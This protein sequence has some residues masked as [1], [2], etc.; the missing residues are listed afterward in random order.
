[1]IG[2]VRVAVIKFINR[3]NKTLVGLKRNLDY[4]LDPKKT[5]ENLIYGKD[6]DYKNAYQDMC[7][8]KY[9]YGK[10]EGRQHIHF[11]QSFSGDELSY[12]LAKKIGQKILEMDIFSGYQ[13]VMATHTDTK[14]TH[15]H[16]VINTVNVDTGEKWKLSKEELQEI[17]DY[18]DELCEENGLQV[19]D[20][21]YKTTREY[22]SL[23]RE[24]T[25]QKEMYEL[26]LNASHESKT[27]ESFFEIIKKNGK[28]LHWDVK[29][30]YSKSKELE[31]ILNACKYHAQ[32]TT[33]FKED[34]AYYGA[35]CTWKVRAMIENK[36]T[37]EKEEKVFN[38]F[39]E[40]EEYKE[41][42]QETIE[43]KS[44]GDEIKFLYEGREYTPAHFIKNL[45]YEGSTLREQFEVNLVRN[46]DK[47][48]PKKLKEVGSSDDYKL[49]YRT[50][51]VARQ[52][53]LNQSEFEEN[54][55]RLGY[56]VTWK[57]SRKY[58]TFLVPKANGGIQKIRNNRFYPK[59]SFT[60]EAFYEVFAFNQKMLEIIREEG[61]SSVDELQE[62]V[63]LG[64][65]KD[66]RI[67]DKNGRIYLKHFFANTPK[68]KGEEQN[69]EENSMEE[70]E[71][72]FDRISLERFFT[73]PE[74][75]KI[76]M[77]DEIVE[78]KEI[79]ENKNIAVIED[80]KGYLFSLTSLSKRFTMDNL[81][82]RFCNNR[83]KEKRKQVV[84][85][86]R[87]IIYCS[88]SMSEFKEKLEIAGYRMEKRKLTKEDRGMI[89][90][91]EQYDHIG[92]EECL[93]FYD[94]E[95]DGFL[96]TFGS[97]GLSEENILRILQKNEE[98]IMAWKR[99]RNFQDFLRG[100]WIFK[101]DDFE[102]E[103]INRKNI[104]GAVEDWIGKRDKRKEKGYE[105]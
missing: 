72:Y 54:M 100:V 57:E 67:D 21:N 89:A 13:V 64:R 22:T 105:R 76:L 44:Y 62:M 19:I 6:C 52:C 61:I 29:K 71:S 82:Q 48:L 69:P 41:N 103:Q 39:E 42:K 43:I 86:I 25:K 2:V 55:E 101:E 81:T 51:Q 99:E 79:K 31:K 74:R 12:E 70:K 77:P 17:K 85:D 16:F 33:E 94:R 47:K 32:S 40:Y 50:I 60:K 92:K 68:G 80:E 15:N 11:T 7:L 78:L 98:R 90:M 3:E 97:K 93:I 38:T 46:E 35:K 37:G 27:L 75:K 95:N 83:F 36:E 58:I 102:A 9:I 56:G 5:N 65:L 63:R 49:L 104:H 28:K 14:N 18:S 24:R 45:R 53:S 20:E 87:S 73:D 4:I 88:S 1:M 91:K 30:D 59:S 34:L 96:S 26:V 84:T 8:T 66:L 10:K 23:R